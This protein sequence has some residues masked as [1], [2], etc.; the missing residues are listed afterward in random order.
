LGRLKGR[1]QKQ[2]CWLKD[3]VNRLIVSGTRLLLQ[4]SVTFIPQKKPLALAAPLERNHNRDALR[5]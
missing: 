5:L 2:T 4:A 3:A 1:E